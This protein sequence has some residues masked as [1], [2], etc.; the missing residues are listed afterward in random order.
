MCVCVVCVSWKGVIDLHTVG[1]FHS[2]TVCDEQHH[3]HPPLPHN[4][5]CAGV[6][7][8]GDPGGVRDARTHWLPRHRREEEGVDESCLLRRQCHGVSVRERSQSVNVMVCVYV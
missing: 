2:H 3:F 5:A 7:D 1:F 4:N 8:E 6:D